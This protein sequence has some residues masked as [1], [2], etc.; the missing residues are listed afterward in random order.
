[1]ARLIPR[2]SVD[3]IA[4]KPERDVARALVEKLPQDC[5]IYHSYPW[6]KSERNDRSGKTT[7]REGETDFVLV[8]PS[9]GILVLE[10][11][12]GV[13]EYN[14]QDR[15]WYRLLDGRNPKIIND[16]FEQARRNTHFLIDRIRDAGLRLDDNKVPFAFG[17]AV[18]FP[19]CKYVGPMPPGAEPIIIL[20]AEDLPYFDRRIPNVL[21]EWN[22]RTEP[23][24]LDKSTLDAI[25]KAISPSF[26]LLPVLFRQIEAQEERLFRLTE[27]QM[28]LLDFLAHH[29]RAAVV[30]VAGSGKTLLAR[31]QAQRF[32]D[33]GKRTLLVCYN[34]ALAEWIR[35][36]LPEAYVGR[37]VV[38]NFHALC[39]DMCKKARIAFNPAGCPDP[40][41][42]WKEDA[43][44]LLLDAIE[45]LPD[46]FDAV[47][48]DEGQDFHADWW[49]ALEQINVN[50][51]KGAMYVF[52]D[53][54]QN[55]FVDGQLSLP[56]LGTPFTLP[57]N[58][59]NTRRIAATCGEI[60]GQTVPT[61]SDAPEGAETIVIDAPT[62]EDQC[63]AVGALL[64]DWVRKGSLKMS[65]IA[66]LSPYRFRNSMLA[67]LKGSR[68]SITESLADWTGNR[69]ILFSTVRAFK[70]LEADAV[71]L[72]DIPKP[73]SA[74][75]FS[76][77]DH[78]V[79]CSRAKHL[80]A[81]VTQA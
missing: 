18:V 79:A 74:S 64:D 58:C 66:I 75:H 2:I 60:I 44:Y 36:T 47:I 48:V 80:L 70:G 61:R 72:V 76:R 63:R 34:K 53:P 42:F 1:M 24:P 37:I 4:L 17:Y 16:P 12:G 40:E 78:Y 45:A 25:Q 41:K 51:A 56:D 26:Q 71:V 28:R 43:A 52:H 69:G 11:K 55:L 15:I 13:I 35:D 81:L 73:G 38:Q 77:A 22:Q 59:R 23:K 33:A 32:A 31:A 20:S 49:P 57:T 68:F 8:L 6:L 62:K 39:D 46:R 67:G 21:C 19:D 3:E 27:D 7:L 5:I 30:G 10:V 9:H 50:G 54:A 14:A 29:Q 65:Q